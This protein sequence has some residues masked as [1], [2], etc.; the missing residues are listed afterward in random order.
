MADV[1]VVGGNGFLGAHLV[2]ALVSDGH[3]VT[4]FD[5]FSSGPSY[6]SSQ[7]RAVVGDFLSRND[8]DL[9]VAGQQ[10]VL[11]LLSTTTPMSAEDDPALDIRTNLE[12]SIE[13][14]EAS[15]R[16]GV[17]HFYLAS[18]GGAIYGDQGKDFYD[19]SVCPQPSSPYAIGK[20]T[21]E[22]FL[23]YFRVRFG[24]S[25]TVLRISNPY[26]PGQR[27]NHRQGLI[28]IALR[29]VASGQPVTRFGDGSMV[30][31]YLFIDDLVKMIRRMVRVIPRQDVYNLGSGVGHTVNQVLAAISRAT[32]MEL[33]VVERPRPT[34]FVERVILDTSRYKAEFGEFELTTLDA[35]VLRTWEALRGEL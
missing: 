21:I 24:L 6:R 2:D 12:Q 1:L 7:V 4:V 5:R 16:A 17:E 34:T 25:S 29:Q 13:L 26:G 28:P 30:R 9:A 32:G 19:E 33:D 31:D 18:T 27:S 3:S 8:I 22:H 20:L 15:V 14:L 35:G 10:V 11:H 23:R